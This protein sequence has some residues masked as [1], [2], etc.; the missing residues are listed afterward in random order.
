[1]LRAIGRLPDDWRYTRDDFY[2]ITSN[3]ISSTEPGFLYMDVGIQARG[4]KDND[5]NINLI[6]IKY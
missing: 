1:M 4:I 3:E 2:V 6:F 5:Q